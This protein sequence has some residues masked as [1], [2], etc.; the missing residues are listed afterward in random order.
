MPWAPRFFARVL[1]ERPAAVSVP[2]MSFQC[3]PPEP[4]AGQKQAAG[5]P[6]GVRRFKQQGI[7]PRMSELSF[8]SPRQQPSLR[9]EPDALTQI[10]DDRKQRTGDR[11]QKTEGFDFGF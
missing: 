5:R 9:K 3:G 4:A 6:V 1:I 10:T 11:K 2:E 8:K 7:L